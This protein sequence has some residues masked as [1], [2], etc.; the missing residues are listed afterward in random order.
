MDNNET[1]YLGRIKPIFFYLK[2]S[3]KFYELDR[4]LITEVLFLILLTVF[5]GGYLLA[6]PYVE[7]FQLYYEQF[8]VRISEAEIVDYTSLDPELVMNLAN[9]M[10][11]SMGIFIAVRAITYF[12][13]IY[14]GSLYFFSLTR[15]DT[16]LAQRNSVVLS[17]VLKVVVFNLLFYLIF[18]IFIFTF[19]LFISVIAKLI[20]TLIVLA[21]SLPAVIILLDL[22]FM[23]KNLLIIEFDVGIT[24]NL[25]KS[26]DITRG[27]K[28]R[29]MSN[30]LFPY[31]LILILGTIAL[32][33]QN[34]L[35]ALFMLAFFEAII[36]MVSN[37][38]TTLMFV[39]A[40]VLKRKDID[41]S[42]EE[43]IE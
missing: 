37:R 5:F 14:Y 24:N 25:K 28:G 29:V 35:L 43:N 19:I 8:S 38:L 9:A 10:L 34:K 12:I 4:P 33:I 20:P 42:A 36:L 3:F 15:P 16:T 39:D 17:K 1:P 18:G 40:A 41:A 11:A 31:L 26:L 23:F 13:G 32:N 30:G 2:D 27:Y 7:D 21:T 6:M 22:M